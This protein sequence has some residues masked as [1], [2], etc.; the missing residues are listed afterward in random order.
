[1]GGFRLILMWHGLLLESI[2]HF[3]EIA[4]SNKYKGDYLTSEIA[5]EDRIYVLPASNLA[6]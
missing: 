3:G 5:S 4:W 6:G 1:M 2:L